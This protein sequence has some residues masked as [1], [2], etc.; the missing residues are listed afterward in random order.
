M[1]GMGGPKP[2][3]LWL[4]LDL[5]GF[6]ERYQR[7]I[8]RKASKALIAHI[9]A[10]FTWARFGAVMVVRR[11]EGEG[12]AA[13]RVLDGQHRVEGARRAGVTSV[14]CIVVPLTGGLREEALAFVGA[15]T[16]R[17]TVGPLQIHRARLAAGDN[18]ASLIARVCKAA[19]IVL[20][21]YPK[22][23]NHLKPGE[24]LA[25][26]TIARVIAEEGAARAT[27][28][29]RLVADVYA[30]EPDR[31]NAPT[32]GAVAALLGKSGKW[33]RAAAL[34]RVLRD[35]LWDDIDE[36]ARRLARQQKCARREALVSVLLDLLA[37]RA[38]RDV[39]REKRGAG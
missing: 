7:S 36:A 21:A 8:E 35:T 28:I 34:R 31:L 9:A 18:G 24:T 12:G 39:A 2:E 3:L 10:N 20:L 25:L 6:D 37:G 16:H 27:E 14:P 33:E 32:I 23:A 29:L 13:Y 11:Q 30:E 17:V 19:G 5:L 26:G 15:N 4:A 22:P 1:S 38:L